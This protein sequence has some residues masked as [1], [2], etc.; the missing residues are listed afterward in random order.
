[1]FKSM[2]NTTRERQAAENV[3]SIKNRLVEII[4][5][6]LPWDAGSRENNVRTVLDK[7]EEFL[8]KEKDMNIVD[9]EAVFITLNSKVGVGSV[10]ND[11]PLDVL[12]GFLFQDY[13][14]HEMR[15]FGIYR[16]INK[17]GREFGFNTN[18]ILENPNTF[19]YG[20]ELEEEK[21]KYS[22]LGKEISDDEVSNRTRIADVSLDRFESGRT[23][24]TIIPKDFSPENPKSN[25]PWIVLIN[26][27]GNIEKFANA[28]GGINVSNLEQTS[29]ESRT[30]NP[31]GT[32][33]NPH[34]D[35]HVFNDPETGVTVSFRKDVLG[36]LRI[37][38]TD[39]NPQTG[40]E[41]ALVVHADSDYRRSHGNLYAEFTT[42]NGASFKYISPVKRE[43]RHVFGQPQ[44][45]N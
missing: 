21:R 10:Y 22:R 3:A 6:D 12:S 31:Q 1:M 5:D 23:Q 24:I 28:D 20:E 44:L 32:N 33:L 34:E 26:E 36:T 43:Q 13:G 30:L 27:D 42:R 38:V 18:K 45:V 4:S 9:V 15:T 11:T 37:L 16:E 7:F 14:W 39:H 25:R 41:L 2:F 40:E 8:L 19:L 17:I 35:S 29:Q